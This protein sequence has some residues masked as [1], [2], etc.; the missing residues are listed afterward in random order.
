MTQFI[1]TVKVILFDRFL[2]SIISQKEQ[3]LMEL[4]RLLETLPPESRTEEET[5]KE[6]R[7]KQ[8]K[9]RKS[10]V[11]FRE[12]E[13]SYANESFMPDEDSSNKSKGKEASS[14]SDRGERI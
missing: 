1:T 9:K 13:P 10:L 4:T 7:G 2:F 8:F 11:Q 12:P 14:S 6:N 3:H 5:S